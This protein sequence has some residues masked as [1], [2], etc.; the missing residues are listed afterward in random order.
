MYTALL[1]LTLP[2]IIAA[3]T[4][5]RCVIEAL[6]LLDLVLKLRYEERLLHAHF[7]N[8]AAYARRTWRVIPGL[9]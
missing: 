6:L 1:L 8:Y 4:L 9:Y 5:P 2:L 3:P 7:S